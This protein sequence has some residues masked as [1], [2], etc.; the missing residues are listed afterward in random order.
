MHI[1]VLRRRLRG[2][3]MNSLSKGKRGERELAAY[4]RD[5]GIDARRGQQYHGGPD[6]PDVVAER[7]PFH[8]EV[9]RCERLSLYPAVDQAAADAGDGVPPLVCHRRNGKD[10]LAV[11][12]LDD[13]L[14]VLGMGG[15]KHADTAENQRQQTVEGA[16]LA[17]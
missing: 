5:H 2:V 10:W 8:L 6:S 7:L 12:R 16:T 13:L 15:R 4:L 1:T 14:E 11:L 9:K 3:S 17:D